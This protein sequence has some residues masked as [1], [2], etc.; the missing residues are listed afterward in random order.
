MRV[1]IPY[2][3]ANP[4]SRLGAILDPSERHSFARAMLADVLAAVRSADAEPVLVTDAA[5]RVPTDD[6]CTVIVTEQSLTPAVNTVL[7][8]VEVPVA[9]IVADVP[10]LTASTVRRFRSTPGDIVLAPGLGGGTNGILIRDP[11]FRVD[12]HGG[13]FRKH[14]TIAEQ[15]DA[16]VRVFDSFRL[17]VDIDEPPDLAEVLL[18]GTGRAAEWLRQAGIEVAMA[19]GRTTAVRGD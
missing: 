10:L 11:G 12:Y 5:I 13:S 18:H 1:L 9:V 17:S 2:S 6:E 19:A 16:T 4:K 14:R 15:R 3:P 7:A 8:T